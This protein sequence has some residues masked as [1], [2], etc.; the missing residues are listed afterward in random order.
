MFQRRQDGSVDFYRDWESYRQGFGDVDGEFWLGNDYLH[1]LTAQG[2][3][4]LRVDLEDFGGDKKSALYSTF[5]V[6]DA[7]DK[8]RLTVGGFSGTPGRSFSLLI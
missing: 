7:S 2:K 8:Y 5:L 6:A 1:R 4:Q 3:Y